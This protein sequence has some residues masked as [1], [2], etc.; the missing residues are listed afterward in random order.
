MQA[1][2]KKFDSLNAILVLMTQSHECSCIIRKNKKKRKENK[3]PE[4]IKKNGLEELKKRIL[5]KYKIYDYKNMIEF[6][7]MLNRAF[8][9]GKFSSESF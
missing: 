2:S 7:A 9:T 3:M 5:K 6:K 1:S 8:S 4:I